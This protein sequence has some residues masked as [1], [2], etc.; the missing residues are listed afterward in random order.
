MPLGLAD[1]VGGDD[2]FLQLVLT[3]LTPLR[4]GLACLGIS[5]H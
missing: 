1:A 2:V 4:L 3:G 5:G